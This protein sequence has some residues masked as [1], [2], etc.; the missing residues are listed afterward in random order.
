MIPIANNTIRVKK[1]NQELVRQTLKA[2]DRMTKAGVAK[3]T[4]LSLGT[5][6][7]ILNEFA[8]AGEVL[9]LATEAS[10]GGRPAQAFKYNMDYAYIA[11]ILVEAGLKQHSVSY[12]VANLAGEAVEEG[13]EEYQ[14]LDF[15]VID[16][17]TG[18]LVARHPEIRA[19]GFGVPGAVNH[20]RMNI[21]DIEE[22][23]GI[24]IES[25]IRGKYGV[26]VIL[27]NDMNLTVYGFCRRQGYEAERPVA[28]ATFIEGSFPGSGLMMN[29]QLHRGD[30]C[31][32][33]E[34]SFLPYGLT[35]EEQFRQ[36]HERSTFP[37][38]AARAV[39]SLIAVVNPQVIAL[40]GSLVQPGDVDRIRRECLENI[41]E[42]H[43][44][45]FMLLDHP[46]E[47]YMHG[48]ITMTLE[49]LSYSY[50]LVEKRH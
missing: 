31:F 13:H 5:C 8:A 12:R 36:L 23:V 38:V 43:M 21:S 46:E 17:L 3:I 6:G 42:M 14:T 10:N 26:E 37:S 34:I 16:Q 40:T 35:R 48:L 33:G 44:P 22:L 15:A 32:A 19:V 7:S 11:C 41:P 1:M 47:D 28:V 24:E 4:G 49:S 25:L 9:E 30:T 39:S 18:R 29:G 27:E 45:Q 20:G 2:N 50:R